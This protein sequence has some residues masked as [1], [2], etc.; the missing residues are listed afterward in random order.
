MR[1]RADKTRLLPR[2]VRRN[3]L[4]LIHVFG[5]EADKRGEAMSNWFAMAAS[6]SA[7]L[8]VGLATT[9][10]AASAQEPGLGQ[11]PDKPAV[12]A[13]DTPV[14]TT[15]ATTATA[16]TDK[17]KA[18]P[19]VAKVETATF[20]GGCF[21]C[22]E[23][24]FEKL[25]GVKDVRSGYAGGDESIGRPSY[26][27]VCTGMTGHA[28]VVRVDFDPS[29]VSY[30]DL[31]DI[32]WLCHNPTTLNSQGPDHGTQYRSVIFYAN[33]AQKKAAEKSYEKVTSQRWFNAPIVTQLV[34]LTKF[35]VAEKYHQDYYRR[36]KSADYCQM[37]ITPKLR[38]L[39]AK[40]AKKA[41]IEEAAK[42]H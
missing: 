8:I 17:D 7:A 26:E 13:A 20:G 31:L 5:F 10:P 29:I 3:L 27:M 32:F 37:V 36:N 25:K 24:V 9:G 22:L 19:D 42:P 34:P 14:P 2:F 6:W 15:P 30:D 39:Q 35:F 23:A 28:E 18:K 33:D 1:S 4:A 41:K 16:P 21:W 12:K 38:D 40:L 11:N